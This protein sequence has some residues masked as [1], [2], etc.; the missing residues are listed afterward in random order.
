MTK[1]YLNV[2]LRNTSRQHRGTKRFCKDLQILLSEANFVDEIILSQFQ[3]QLKKTNT[4]CLLSSIRL[5]ND[6]LRRYLH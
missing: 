3:I 1:E 6:A 5:A 4:V 2:S